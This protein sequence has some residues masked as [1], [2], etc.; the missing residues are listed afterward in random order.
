[1]KN[2]YLLV[3]ALIGGFAVN[4]QMQPS[5]S[6]SAKHDRNEVRPVALKAQNT[7]KAEGQLWWSNQFNT[8]AEWAHVSGTG[9]LGMQGVWNIINAIPSTITAQQAQYQWPATFTGA[10][11]NFAFIDSDGA[12]ASGVQDAYFQFQGNIDLSGAGNA[13]MY[14]TFAEYY[15][16]FQEQNFVEVSNDGGTTWTSFAVNTVAEVPVNTNSVPGE[17]ETVNITSAKGTGPWTNQV[18]I[19]FHYVG[20]YDWFWGIDDVKIVEAWDNDIKMVT[21]FQATDMDNT[22]GLDYYHIP[23]SQ[24]SFP[25]LTFG[26]NV[27]NNGALNQT[28]VSLK[29][30]ATDGYDQTGTAISINTSSTDSVSVTTPYI[31]T[32]SGT[33]TVNLTTVIAGTDADVTNNTA[34]FSMFKNNYQY[35]RDN[36]IQSGSIG[37]VSSQPGQALKIGNVME[38]F[39]NMTVSNIA[40]RLATQQA[41]AV[42]NEYFAE[43]HKYN[44]TTEEWEYL[45]ETTY[46]EVAN[47]TATWVSLPVAGGPVV[48]NAGDV[49]LLVACH[50]GGTPEIRFGLAQNTL[51]SS[52]LGFTADGNS[53]RLTSPSAVMIRLSDEPLSV[54]EI[55]NTIGMAVYPNPANT[56]TTISFNLSNE[57]NTVVNVTDLTGKQ[58]YSQNLG[59]VN[60]AQKVSIDTENLTSGVYMVNVIVDGAVST[61]KLVVR[62]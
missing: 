31:P 19:R 46:G 9:Q 49:I 20:A 14:I 4:A 38:I 16:H 41:N 59:S 28:S 29:A 24:S 56:S 62:K 15:R 26:A 30:T 10:S 37:N 53:F 44:S 48:L 52:V 42:S 43:I 50:F 36:N 23:T 13:A 54:S 47:T 57:Q 6:V 3:G 34:S 12:G 27:L 58:V 25:G 32:G 18:K 33:K 61:Q 17:V 51:E 60:G 35:S 11:G 2:L 39:D 8:P 21:W 45:A 22:Q 55:E 5:F 1:M 40:I 7:V